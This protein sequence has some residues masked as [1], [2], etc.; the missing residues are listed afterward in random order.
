MDLAQINCCILIPTYN[1]QKTLA[2]V[3]DGVLKF[4]RSGDVIVIND[5]STDL[6]SEILSTYHN[7][8]TLLVNN[9]NSGKGFSLRKGFAKATELGF[10][11]AIT[12]DSDGQ[13]F[14][15]DIPKL[16]S[17]ALENRGALLMGTRNMQ[18]EGVPG[19]SLTGNKISNFWYWVE[20]GNKLAD[21]QTGFRLYPLE[22]IKKIKL[23][24]TKFETEIEL[25]V[26]LAWQDVKVIPVEI[27]VLYDSNERVSHFRP[28]KDFT[29]I[30]I[31]HTY[32]VT[33]SVIYYI[34]KRLLQKLAKRRV[35]QLIK[36]EALKEESALKKSASIGFGFFMGIAPVWGFQL[37]IG[38]PLSFLFKLNKVLFI[39][40]ANISFPPLIPVIIYLSYLTGSFFVS[41]KTEFLN[42]DHVTLKSI[43]VNFVQYFIGAWIL[44]FASGLVSLIVSYGIIKASKLALSNH[45]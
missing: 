15:D 19:K 29:R 17:A 40:A 1:N 23:I 43:E 25:I 24:T 27:N 38:I 22:P 30:G 18:Q 5:G 14:P 13:H 36:A 10:E 32:Y 44:A 37:L 35:F 20:T 8:I 26:K 28:F 6:T 21:T 12:I 45:N 33:I 11:N 2:R 34:P 4:S 7:K 42:W 9:K 16:I 31:I 39:A 41:N 3:I